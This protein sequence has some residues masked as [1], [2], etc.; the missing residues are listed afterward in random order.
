[1][2]DEVGH[3]VGRSVGDRVGCLV[4]S[5]VPLPPLGFRCVDITMF[6]CFCVGRVV[7]SFVGK[8]VPPPLLM[9]LVGNDVN[10][11]L[12]GKGLGIHVGRFVFGLVV[13][14]RVGRFVFLVGEGLGLDVGRFVF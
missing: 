10:F 5:D 1:M 11:V 9:I 12:V 6:F 4:G 13:G 14:N 8:A 2:G 7:G 3:V